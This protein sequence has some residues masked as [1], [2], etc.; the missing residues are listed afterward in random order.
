MS[1]DDFPR[2][3]ERPRFEPEIIPPDRGGRA[4]RGDGYVWV[5]TDG[6][7]TRRIYLARPGPFSIF[8]ALILA[9]LVLVAIVLVVAGVILFWIPV[10]V[11][12]VATLLL[13]G[14][15]R[16]YWARLKHWFNARRM[17]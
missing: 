16:Y 15:S 11:L 13:A 7:G 2:E 14:Y 9:G 4:G 8:V 10:I 6:R 5:S 1:R 17:R 12:I 3:P